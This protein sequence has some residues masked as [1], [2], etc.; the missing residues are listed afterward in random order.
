M[1]QAEAVEATIFLPAC[2]LVCPSYSGVRQGALSS[3]PSPQGV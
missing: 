1:S 3:A 2:L